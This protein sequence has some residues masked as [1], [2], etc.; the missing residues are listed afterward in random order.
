[1]AKITRREFVRV[2][3][4]WAAGAAMAG[5]AEAAFGQ[6]PGGGEELIR[7][8]KA[9]R[10]FDLSHTWDE[11]SPL[12]P[13]NPPYAFAVNRTHQET[14][15]VF[16][17]AP[18]SQVSWTSEI[19]YFS[20]QHGAPSIDA[21]G[22]VGR[23]LRLH[24]GVD[25]PAASSASGGLG[26]NLG[27]D[28]YP[29]DL[30]VN[31]GVL[32]DVARFVAGGKADPLPPGFEITARHLE[33]TARAQGVELRKGDSV[34]IRTGFGQHFGKKNDVYLGEGSPGPGVDGARFLVARGVR[35]TGDDTATYEKRPPVHGKELFPVHMLL[36]ADHGIYIVENF[37][38]EEIAAAKVHTFLLVLNPLKLRGASGSPL[39]AFALAPAKASSE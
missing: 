31:R 1:M 6:S 11:R 33:D 36:L 26:S 2:A 18:G 7:L 13:L 16:G 12:L 17:S 20:G 15:E 32:L 28:A 22:H 27:I 37:A 5:G 21:L 25:A 38:L 8:A 39:R 30:L 19:L 29:V 24:G 23:N 34:L 3:G 10:I 14:Y 4:A 35:L 9:A